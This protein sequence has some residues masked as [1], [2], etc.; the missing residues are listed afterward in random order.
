MGVTAAVKHNKWQDQAMRVFAIVGWSFPSFVVGLLL[1][2]IFYAQRQWF[3]PGRLSDWAS[4]VVN[5]AALFERKPIEQIDDAAWRRMIDVNLSG[6]FFCCRAAL[7]IMNPQRSGAIVN[8]DRRMQPCFWPQ[9]SWGWPF[10]RR[11][12]SGPTRNI[13]CKSSRR[14]WSQ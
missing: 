7:R 13:F 8:I 5:S 14:C 1:L 2:M 12:Y 9:A 6:P 4:V 3:P 10:P 11:H